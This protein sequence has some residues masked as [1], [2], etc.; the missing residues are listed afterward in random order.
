VNKIVKEAN[1]KIVCEYFK[2]S[3]VFAWDISVPANKIKVAR[4]ILKEK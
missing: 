3:K 4:K 2:K 1:G